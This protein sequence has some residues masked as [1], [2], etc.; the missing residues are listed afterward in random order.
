MATDA[1]SVALAERW[2]GKLW[3]L[4]QPGREPPAA[5]TTADLAALLCADLPSGAFG[6]ESLAA[7]AKD[8]E[9]FPPPK[10]LLTAL[11]SWW[12]QH[13]PA[14]A[15]SSRDPAFMELAPMDRL[16]VEYWDRRKPECEAADRGRHPDADPAQSKVAILASLVRTYSKPAWRYIRGSDG[17]VPV[18][19]AADLE[20]ARASVGAAVAHMQRRP[21]TPR[22]ASLGDQMA[23]VRTSMAPA[24][25]SAPVAPDVLEAMR[26][27][28]HAVQA[29]RAAQAAATRG[30]WD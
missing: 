3:S 25:K 28:S 13:R 29:A 6:S 11:Q 21:S 20:A 1:Q 8:C 16:W 2:L 7:I 18:P 15:P 17:S 30:L 26:A 14:L 19:T 10:V 23:A 22:A 27:A 24:R 9:R 12:N 4:V 5:G